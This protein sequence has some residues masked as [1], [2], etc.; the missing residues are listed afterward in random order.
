ML[1]VTIVSVKNPLI[2]KVGFSTNYVIENI[3]L[4]EKEKQLYKSLGEVDSVMSI[5]NLEK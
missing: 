4:P 3:R 2:K 5:L 1:S